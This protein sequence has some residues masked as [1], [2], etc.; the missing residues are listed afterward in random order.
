MA[1]VFGGEVLWSRWEAGAA[2]P[3]AVFHYS[4]PWQQSHFMLLLPALWKNLQTPPA[5]HGEFTVDP[6]AGQFCASRSKRK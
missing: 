5:Y 6:A 3:L 2:G 4:V 1:D